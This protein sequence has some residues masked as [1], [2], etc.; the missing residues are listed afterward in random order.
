[1]HG[2]TDVD[3]QPDPNSW[4]GVLDRLAEEPF[5]RAY[6]QRVRELLDPTPGR[7]Y[8]E[9]GAGTGA[10]AAHLRDAHGVSVATVDRSLTMAAAM[11]ARGLTGCAAADAH[12]LPFRTHA[13][14]GAWADRTVQHLADPHA[15]VTDLVRVVRPGGR[16]VLADPDYDTQVLDIADQELARRVLRFRADALLRNG[17]LAHRHAGLLAAH[18][19]VDITVEPRTLVVRDPTAVDNVLGLR[20][21]AATAAQRGALDP[22]EARAFEDQFDEAVRTHRFTYAV[23]FFLTAATVT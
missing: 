12:H 6:Q 8:L 20:S 15:A 17:T 4:V 23:T 22:S 16:I 19:L 3:R 11:R 21:W 9:V 7:R 2:F 10:S 18:G 13:F 14:D 5:Y 1:M